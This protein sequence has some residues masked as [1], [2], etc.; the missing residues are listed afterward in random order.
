MATVGLTLL[1]L[2][3]GGLLVLCLYLA[4]TISVRK[5]SALGKLGRAVYTA[6]AF[7]G[8]YSYSIYLWHIAVLVWAPVVLRRALHLNLSSAAAKTLYFVV[9]LGV[10]IFLSRLIEYPM[11]RVRDR[12]FPG[13]VS[14][15]ATRA[16]DGGPN[17]KR[18]G[19][20]VETRLNAERT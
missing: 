10:G 7:V 3:F 19:I 13:M 2:G 17:T 1:Y 4:T 11:L 5:P 14:N 20:K 9:S 8:M 16:A 18:N 6:F 15:V 12:L